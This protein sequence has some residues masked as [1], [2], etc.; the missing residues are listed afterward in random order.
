MTDDKDPRTTRYSQTH[1]KESMGA[2][3]TTA[4]TERKPR[5]GPM[6][7]EPR[8]LAELDE[9]IGS[10]I[11]LFQNIVLDD[12]RLREQRLRTEIGAVVSRV[13]VLEDEVRSAATFAAK[14]ACLASRRCRRATLGP[15]CVATCRV[16]SSATYAVI[17]TPADSASVANASRCSG[18]RRNAT[19]GHALAPRAPGRPTGRF[20]A[21]TCA[22][23]GPRRIFG[24]APSAA[25]VFRPRAAYRAAEPARSP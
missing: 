12:A 24:R 13:D 18:A 7:R 21:L 4:Q 17:D 20:S 5:P 6:P 15:V 25:A 1:T 8:T 22:S 10:R 2:V 23:H 14:A 16:T 11:S 3:D 9:S 19:C